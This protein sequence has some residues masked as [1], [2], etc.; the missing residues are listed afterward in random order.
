MQEFADRKTYDIANSTLKAKACGCGDRFYVE[1]NQAAD[2]DEIVLFATKTCPNC[3]M[4]KRLLDAAGVKYKVID[5]EE[6]P[7][8]TKRFNVKKAPT[9]FVPEKGSYIRYE[10]ASEINRFVE[11][12][13]KR[14]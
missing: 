10:N 7:E 12:L 11:G 13:K 2:T 9:L 8:L 1:D 6:N 3:K 14:A 5:A 4:A